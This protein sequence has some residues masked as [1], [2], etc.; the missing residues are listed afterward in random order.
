MRAYYIGSN[1]EVGLEHLKELGVLYWKLDADNWE[2][3]GLLDK[4]RKER[5]YKNHD[6]VCSLFV[7]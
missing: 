2:Q 6:V 4:I 5:S 3:E 1:G 7:K